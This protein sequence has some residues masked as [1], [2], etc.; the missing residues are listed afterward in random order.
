MSSNVTYTSD[1]INNIWKVTLEGEIDIY[2]SD[3]VKAK[4]ISMIDEK[5][6]NVSVDCRKLT[7]IDSTGLSALVALL[8][9]VKAYSGDVTLKGLM[10]NVYKVIK[11]TN[12]D[13][14]FIIDNTDDEKD[15]EGDADE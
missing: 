4:L 8:K 7:Y 9:K 6:Q 14:V 5:E 3:E 11:I 10:P 15:T 1:K 13:K 2:N 12:L